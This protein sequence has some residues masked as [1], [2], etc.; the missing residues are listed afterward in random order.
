[1]ADELDDEFY[2]RADAHINFPTH[3]WKMHGGALLVLR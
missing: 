1:M 3:N 2:D